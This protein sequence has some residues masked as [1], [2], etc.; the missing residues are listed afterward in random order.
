MTRPWRFRSED[1]H[2]ISSHALLGRALGIQGQQACEHLVAD[3]IGPAVAPGFI[4][5]APGFFV[6]LV[7]Q[8]ELAIGRDVSPA[9][10]IQNDAV[11]CGVKLA[12]PRDPGIAIVRIVKTVVCFCQS[13]V[14][15][16]HQCRTIFVVRLTCCFECGVRFPVVGEWESLEA[17]GG[18]ILKIILQSR[19]KESCPDFMGARLKGSKGRKVREW[20]NN[21]LFVSNT[22]PWKKCQC[23]GVADSRYNQHAIEAGNWQHNNPWR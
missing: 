10:G 6:D 17:V 20:K 19:A 14:A 5:P 7:I 9:I 1:E 3:F 22:L 4:L 11:H 13:L 16:D 8:Q 2:R 21:N 12:E 23:K 18:C 15:L